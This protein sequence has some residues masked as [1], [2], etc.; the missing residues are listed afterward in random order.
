MSDIKSD[1]AETMISA[2]HELSLYIAEANQELRMKV[3]SQTES[4]PDWHD[5][6][7]CYELAQDA[8]RV[9]AMQARIVELEKALT[10]IKKHQEA[11]IFKMPELSTAWQI[12]SRALEK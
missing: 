5:T 2:A 7:T 12:A 10:N 8:K 6:Q 11:T 4:E 1:I 9:I 3:H